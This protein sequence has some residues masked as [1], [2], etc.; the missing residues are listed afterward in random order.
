MSSPNKQLN[1]RLS[2]PLYEVLDAAAFVKR[3]S[4]SSLAKETV[5]AAVERY[6]KETPVQAALRA[7]E[8]EEAAASGE[9]ARISGARSRRPKKR[10]RS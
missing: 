8:E 10:A 3:S 1:I 2:P 9:I 5:E 6:A 4:P 7:R